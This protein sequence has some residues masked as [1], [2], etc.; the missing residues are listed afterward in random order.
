MNEKP[1]KIIT[2]VDINYENLPLKD[3]TEIHRLFYDKG[4]TGS[5]RQKLHKIIFRLEPPTPSQ[6]LDYTNGWITKPFQD[7]IYD[8]VKE[9]FCEI[10]N[11]DGILDED[12]NYD[13]I[14]EYGATRLGKSYLSRML[15][16]YIIIFV[17]CLRHPQLFY[18]LA[19]TTPL[20][21]FILSFVTEKVNQ[22]LLD[23]LYKV[24]EMSPRFKKVKFQDQVKERQEIEGLENIIWSKA[25]TGSEITVES[26]LTLNIGTDY[27]SFIGSNLLF[28]TVSE[29][30]FFI[31]KAGATHEQIFQLYTDG[32]ARIQA[33]VGSNY[34]G[35]VFLDSS[36]NDLENPIE[37]YILKDLKKQSKVFFKHR[38]KW[39]D[40]DGIRKSIGT[41]K[42]PKWIA[43]GKTFKISIGNNSL[44]A[45]IIEDKKELKDIPKNILYDIPI[46][47]KKN[48]ERNILKAIKDDLGLPTKKE[49]KFIQDPSMIEK[50]FDN[51]TIVNIE[52]A[53]IADASELPQNLLWDKIRTLYFSK[54]T[55]T[56]YV[57]K[58]AQKEARFLGFDL[59][60]AVKGDIQ[61]VAL[62]HIEW[63]RE[64]KKPI[65]VY[66]FAFGIM[67]KDTGINLEA[68]TYLII[69]LVEIGGIWIHGCYGDSFQSQTLVQTLT[70]NNILVV[71]QSVDKLIEPYQTFFTYT[72]NEQIKS[73]KNIYFKNNLDSLIITKRKGKQVID[74]SQGRTEN[75][76]TGNWNISKCGVNA[77]DV[78][79]AA[80]QSFWGAVNSDIIPTT[81]Y[82]DENLKFNP[83][84]DNQPL[85]EE[86]FK[87]LHRFG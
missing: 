12:K 32:L 25:G 16:H 59:A 74:H 55:Q 28:L 79:D 10:L 84:E 44:P 83:E 29:I 1:N 68:L 77:K 22:L 76:Y 56:A 21:I 86:A 5:L 54:Y 33:T 70:R 66:D 18:G 78:S 43:T 85:I 6:Y 69:D 63:S 67:G 34:L 72:I 71:K 2:S 75:T 52:H 30:N 47:L 3:Q 80:C 45:K 39:N 38:A 36:A 61:G 15:I 40:S 11:P 50:I 24:F 31:E 19:P 81:I 48:F 7:S 60:H 26:G 9:D 62:L 13:Q 65:Y 23:P 4:I 53:L 35:M 37:Q 64:L 51:K 57:I 49:N 27:L 58:R 14:V 42:L 46:D 17:H 82:E 20:S 41:V 87:K 73:G 8:H